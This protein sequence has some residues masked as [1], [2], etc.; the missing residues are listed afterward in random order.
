MLFL[1]LESATSHQ[2]VA[3]FRDH[4][5]LA[6]LDCEAR[7]PLTPQLIP[8][9]DR[10]LSSVSLQLSNLEGLAVSIGPGTFTG[11]RVGLSTMTAFRLALQIPLVG[12]TTLE[13]LAWNHPVTELP[14][15]STVGIREGM[16]YW[17][18]FRWENQQMVC[19]KESQIGDIL[20]VCSSLTEPTI[21]LGDGWM[22]N[23]EALLPKGFSI[24]EAPPEKQWPSAK[25]IGM[26][27]RGL[28]ER[29]TLLPLGCSPQYIQPSYAEI[30]KTKSLNTLG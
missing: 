22:R 4:Q 17:A 6:S 11:L 23:R 18:L 8:T 25:G 26:A 1:A 24:V 2:S 27:G 30:S 14:L 15:L 21:V 16:V 7:Q 12:V 19:V 28:L 5:L 20:D 3:V 9:I 29:G 13:G 10:L